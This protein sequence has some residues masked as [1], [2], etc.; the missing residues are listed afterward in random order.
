[1][2]RVKFRSDNK[3]EKEFSREVRKRVRVY[4]KDNNISIHGNYNMYLKTFVMLGLYLAP[5]ILLLTIPITPW[6]A[7]AMVVLMGIGEA[8]IGM[9]IMHDGA[10]GAY[11]SKP[12]VNKMAASTMF[13]L[14]SNTFNWKIQ[15]NIQHHTFTNMF[16]FDPDISTKAVVRLS[17][18]STL[19]K[20]H[21]FQHLYSFF[22]YG[23]ATLM[24]LFGDIGVLL[25]HN[26]K[27]ITKDQKSSPVLEFVKLAAT[28]LIYLGVIFGLPMW[29][30]EFSFW[31]IFLGFAIM[32]MTAG[33]IMTTVF[34]MAHVVEGTYQPL[35]DENNIFHTEWLVH[36]LRATSDFGRKNG[37]LSWY[38]GGLD[39]Q[40]EHHMFTNICHIHY[41]AIAPIIEGTAKEFGFTYNLKPNVF[42]ALAS[43]YR[44]LREL[45]REKNNTNFERLSIQQK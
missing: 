3:T 17:D 23:F 34:Q 25:K 24:R 40:V 14:G 4:F 29:L 45:G 19:K 6:A 13:L 32:Q 38:I 11:S 12:W 26:R 37:L 22:L 21:R 16:D 7:L 1:M 15:H 43:H 39:Y 41:S 30:T 33:I 9:S 31:Q 18:H 20:Y 42:S 35:P 36:Q 5:F 27:G 10:H 8:G 28:K 2:E 44:R